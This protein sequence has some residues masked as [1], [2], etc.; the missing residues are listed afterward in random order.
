MLPQPTT[1]PKIYLMINDKFSDLLLLIFHIPGYNKVKIKDSEILLGQEN[2]NPKHCTPVLVFSVRYCRI[3]ERN[4]L[5]R[6]Q[7]RPAMCNYGLWAC[8]RPIIG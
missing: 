1:Q 7:D 5:H 4:Q 3:F 2:E 8:N 6:M